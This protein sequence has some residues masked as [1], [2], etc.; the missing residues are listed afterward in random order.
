MTQ[1]ERLQLHYQ[2]SGNPAN[3][4]VLFLHGFMGSG[5]DWNEVIEFLSPQYYCLTVDLPGHGGTGLDKNID[6]SFEKTA[7]AMMET[8]RQSDIKKCFLVG[9]SMGGRLA[10]F[11]TLRY[12]RYFSKTVL[13]SA[14]PG[15]RTQQER[16]VRR[17]QDSQISEELKKGPFKSFLEK[18]YRKHVFQGITGGRG[19]TRLITDRLQNDPKMLAQSLRFLG[20]GKQ[21]SLW[22]EL[23]QNENPLFL[24][25]GENDIK[26]QAIAGEM[27][28][29]NRS[30]KTKIIEGCSH[31]IHF[32]E[33]ELF[34][35]YINEFFTEN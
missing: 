23:P 20:T 25:V 1:S 15:L 26:F 13:E 29:L 2:T 33:P 34:A 4:P 14:S 12:P 5:N 11:L 31:N 10:L 18:W 19:F 28:K 30:I 8:M 21:P 32:Q 9:Y 17:I 6:Y 27:A 22:D 24:L 35:Q 3:L 16:E 7:I